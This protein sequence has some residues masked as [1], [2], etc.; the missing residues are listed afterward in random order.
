MRYT[1]TTLGDIDEMLRRIRPR[2]AAE[3]EMSGNSVPYTLG[4]S[5]A[6][7]MVVYSANDERTGRL[8]FIGGIVHKPNSPMDDIIWGVGTVEMDRNPIKALKMTKEL[9]KFLMDKSPAK[10]FHNAIPASYSTY[11]KWAKE[12]LSAT[13]DGEIISLTGQK[14]VKFTIV[15]GG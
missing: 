5:F 2:D 13:F 8:F 1:R 15:K 4:F 11:L 14:F 10:R 9:S 3:L 7:S 6:E 12:H